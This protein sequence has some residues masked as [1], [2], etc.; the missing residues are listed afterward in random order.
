[1]GTRSMILCAAG[2][3]ML[4]SPAAAMDTAFSYQGRL[5]DA[6]VPANGDYDSRFAPSA[7]THFDVGNGL[8]LAGGI[9]SVDPTDFNGSSPIGASTSGAASPSVPDEWV[10]LDSLT[11]TA[12]ANGRILIIGSGLWSCSSGCGEFT[13]GTCN[14]SLGLGGANA[15]GG[16]WA[17][18]KENNETVRFHFFEPWLVNEGTDYPFELW[19]KN[20]LSSGPGTE[21]S[22]VGEMLYV[23]LPN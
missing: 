23:F 11:F 6:G 21:F 3:L 13:P 7:H 10:L 4:G 9:L 20:S 18:F 15:S 16:T 8:D 5:K 2:F 14:A 22:V 12:P 19:V 17:E 1:M